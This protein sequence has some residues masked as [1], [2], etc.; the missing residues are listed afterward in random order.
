MKED[1][2]PAEQVKVDAQIAKGPFIADWMVK[3]V[4]TSLP[5]LTSEDTI[6]QALKESG[7]SVDGAVSTLMEDPPSAPGTPGSFS[8]SGSSSIERDLDSD[9]EEI[10]GPNKRQNRTIRATKTSKKVKEAREKR[11]AELQAIP[12]IE[13]TKPE[14]DAASDIVEI[15]GHNPSKFKAEDD[16]YIA[17]SGDDASE[18]SASSHSQSVAASTPPPTRTQQPKIILRTKTS[19]RQHGP[20]AKKPRARDIK[21][22]KKAAQK[23]ARKERARKDSQPTPQLAKSTIN[24]N[25]KRSSPPM[26]QVIGMKTLYI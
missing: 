20:T 13:L 22:M 19:Q 23:Q 6:R 4:T 14:S 7:G 11:E 16:E 18:Y 5:H 2:T 3:A 25:T 8:Q 9:D 21:E 26:E 17:P 24:V 15:A 12:T 10:Y 1:I